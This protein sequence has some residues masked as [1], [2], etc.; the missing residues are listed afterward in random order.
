MHSRQLDIAFE[1]KP[2]E[3]ITGDLWIDQICSWNGLGLSSLGT[4]SDGGRLTSQRS[5]GIKEPG[6]DYG[7]VRSGDP[8]SSSHKNMGYPQTVPGERCSAATFVCVQLAGVHWH[9]S[10]LVS[11]LSPLKR[12]V[13]NNNTAWL[14]ATTALTSCDC[15]ESGRWIRGIWCVGG[16][17]DDGGSGPIAGMFVASLS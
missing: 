15:D 6:T 14:E 16:G 11:S 2:V 13:D 5:P 8:S 12:C 4:W 1:N 7:L 17:E 9:A 3:Q 10:T